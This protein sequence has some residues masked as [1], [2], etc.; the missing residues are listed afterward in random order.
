MLAKKNTRKNIL[1][2]PT[3]KYLKPEFIIVTGNNWY[4]FRKNIFMYL[5][6][7]DLLERSCII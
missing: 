5:C 4:I 1:S 3:Q 6:D 2:R 7:R